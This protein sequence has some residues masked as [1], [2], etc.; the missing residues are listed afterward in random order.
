MARLDRL[1]PGSSVRG[2]IAGAAAKVVQVEWFGD[3]AVEVAF[4]EPGGAARNRLLYRTDE[5]SLEL[6]VVGRAWSFAGDGELFR[7]VSEA[8]R[9]RLAGIISAASGQERHDGPLR[10][11][12]AGTRLHALDVARKRAEGGPVL[13]ALAGGGGAAGFHGRG[14]SS[15]GRSSDV[16]AGFDQW[17]AQ[18]RAVRR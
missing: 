4:E 16:C 10:P 6:V 2:L 18:T 1:T 15:G 3:Q 17:G 8:Q 5:P 13:R 14:R 11:V 12:K 9:I 7:L